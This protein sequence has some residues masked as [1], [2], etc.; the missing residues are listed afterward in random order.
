MTLEQ[1]RQAIYSHF[2]SIST[3]LYA[4]D[5]VYFRNQEEPDLA[6]YPKKTFV[7]AEV[8]LN[9]VAQMAITGPDSRLTRYWGIFETSIFVPKGSGAKTMTEFIDLIDSNYKMTTIG[10][11]VFR[12]PRPAAPPEPGIGWVKQVVLAPFY[13]E[14][15]T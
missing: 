13:F 5:S 6:T 12:V 11:I 15:N 4:A 9:D 14:S 8:Y 2:L 7:L 10:G 3:S 1:A